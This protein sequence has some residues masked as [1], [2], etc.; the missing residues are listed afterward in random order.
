MNSLRHWRGGHHRW[1]RYG[2]GN[3]ELKLIWVNTYHTGKLEEEIEV[4]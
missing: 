2:K 1:Q 3:K 4:N